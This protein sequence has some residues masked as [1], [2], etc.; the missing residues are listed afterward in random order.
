MKPESGYSSL[1]KGRF[2]YKNHYYHLIFSTKNRKPTF[3]SFGNSRLFINILKEDQA[4][5]QSKTL[6]FVV[7]PDHVHWLMIVKKADLSKTVKRIKS[8][9]SRYIAE[10]QW[11]DGFYDHMI[12]SDEN[13]RTVARYI[14]ANPVR[15]CMVRSVRGYSHWDAIWL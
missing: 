13:L 12:R 5:Q 8:I 4:R 15:A 7:M 6:A 1:R 9:S 14:V 11:S 2:S 3:E 10:L